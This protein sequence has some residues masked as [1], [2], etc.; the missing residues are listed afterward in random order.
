[1]YSL[2]PRVWEPEAQTS[3]GSRMCTFKSLPRCIELEST[4]WQR[5]HVIHMHI[6]V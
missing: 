4:V 5:A 6:K 2:A 3:P 1:M